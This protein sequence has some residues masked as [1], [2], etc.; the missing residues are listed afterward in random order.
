MSISG[1]TVGP[2]KLPQ[3]LAGVEVG[4][5]VEVTVAVGVGKSVGKYVEVGPIGMKGVAVA[6]EPGGA[7]II[8]VEAEI[9]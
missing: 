3:G 4:S 8:G 1:Q 9:A 5:G 6:V 7:T 2:A